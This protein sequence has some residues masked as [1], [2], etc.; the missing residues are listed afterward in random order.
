MRAGGGENEII[1]IIGNNGVGKTTLIK[2]CLDIL[3]YEGEILYLDRN[4]RK[5]NKAE[6][7]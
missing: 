2:S 3:T 7:S 4:L 5:M 1:G 6:K